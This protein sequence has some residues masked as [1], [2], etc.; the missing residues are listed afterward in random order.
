[1][2]VMDSVL[3]E[4]MMNCE[5]YHDHDDPRGCERKVIHRTGFD[6]GGSRNEEL[7]REG[8]R[9]VGGV[10]MKISLPFHG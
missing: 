3:G 4:Q 1:M 10:E 6:P 2:I 9:G 5:G 8:E 7:E